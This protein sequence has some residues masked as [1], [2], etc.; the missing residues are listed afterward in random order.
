MAVVVLL[1]IGAISLMLVGIYRSNLAKG[2]VD[3]ATGGAFGFN[4]GLVWSV[5]LLGIGLMEWGTDAL[6]LLGIGGTALTIAGTAL[7][8]G[9]AC[10]RRNTPS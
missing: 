9:H 8:V 7:G 6:P 4:I 2:H 3:L 5:G 1:F 10:M